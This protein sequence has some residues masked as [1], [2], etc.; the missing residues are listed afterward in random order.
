MIPVGEVGD[1]TVR[2]CPGQDRANRLPA[3]LRIIQRRKQ[4][5]EERVPTEQR[6]IVRFPIGP[7]ASDRVEDHSV[8]AAV[9]AGVV[10]ILG[11]WTD[12]VTPIASR[13]RT[14]GQITFF[15]GG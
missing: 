5:I 13:D 7:S 3:S 9:N 10:E 6:R 15:G 8:I 2:G 4:A 12:K 11:N 1:K 14:M